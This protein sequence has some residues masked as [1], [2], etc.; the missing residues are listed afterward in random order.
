VFRYKTTGLKILYCLLACFTRIH[1][2]FTRCCPDALAVSCLT[3]GDGVWRC[4]TCVSNGRST[5]SGLTVST[6]VLITHE[7]GSLAHTRA[8]VQVSFV[9]I[10]LG[11][12]SGDCAL[13]VSVKFKFK[14]CLFFPAGHCV[15]EKFESLV[16]K[17]IS[18]DE[19]ALP[20]PQIG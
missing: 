18:C 11:S 1:N 6:E 2:L 16:T 20:R 5:L 8:I 3:L 19:A 15:Y 13:E 14:F 12:G 17:Q 10:V 4:R 9:F 7:T